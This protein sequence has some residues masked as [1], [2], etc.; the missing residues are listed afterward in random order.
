MHYLEVNLLWL[1]MPH[2]G[3]ET[4][5]QRCLRY[6]CLGVLVGQHT[7]L[8]GPCLVLEDT[9]LLPWSDDGVE[10]VVDLDSFHAVSHRRL[11]LV[12][13]QDLIKMLG[14]HTLGDHW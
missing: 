10:E 13:I 12:G 9:I 4:R 1:M 2:L 6:V 8:T 3:V 11:A 7:A 5:V 14:R